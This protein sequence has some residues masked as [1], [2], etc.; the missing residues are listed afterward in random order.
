M[1]I[2]LS[3]KCKF[4]KWYECS[5]ILIELPQKMILKSTFETIQKSEMNGQ[6]ET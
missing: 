2:G 3:V 5:Q 1:L 4:W 6:K